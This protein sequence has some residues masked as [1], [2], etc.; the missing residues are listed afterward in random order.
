[1]ACEDEKTLVGRCSTRKHT[2][3]SWNALRDDPGSLCVA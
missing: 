1:M 2:A 3:G